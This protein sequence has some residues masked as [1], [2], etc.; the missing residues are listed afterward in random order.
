MWR[1]NIHFDI[2]LLGGK[3]PSLDP[4]GRSRGVSREPM[5]SCLTFTR[6]RALG[7][8]QATAMNRIKY[9]RAFPERAGSLNFRIQ[10]TLT[11]Y[12]N[13]SGHWDGRKPNDGPPHA[14]SI[15]I[16]SKLIQKRWVRKKC[17]ASSML[18][19]KSTVAHYLGG[20]PKKVEGLR[21]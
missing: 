16:D 14:N 5:H 19:S 2:F 11:S 1:E 9:Q 6:D 18:W 15:F 20:R 8:L 13:G 12:E 10:K 7:T 3:I 21:T 17:S 4:G